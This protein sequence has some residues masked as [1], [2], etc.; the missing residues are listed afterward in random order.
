M[1]C[2]RSHYSAEPRREA[3]GGVRL[4]V[5]SSKPLGGR[6]LFILCRG[7]SRF[8]S[9]ISVR[10]L[11]GILE[12]PSFWLQNGVV[13]QAVV[14]KILLRVIILLR[15]LG[16]DSLG[17]SE[18]LGSDSDT[19]GVDILCT[20]VLAGVQNWFWGRRPTDIHSEYWYRDFR[21]VV[22]LLRQ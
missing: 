7:I 21:E 15:D 5:S 6:S 17:D 16:V 10:Y 1:V 18:H 8:A 3:I 4:R 9:L 12:L 14:G 2:R 11:G 22:K 19:E 20:A 13:F